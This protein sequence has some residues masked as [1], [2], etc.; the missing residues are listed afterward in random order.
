MRLAAFALLL[1][2]N[3]YAQPKP[4]AD[5]KPDSNGCNRGNAKACL[6][7]GIA[8][9]KGTGGVIKDETKAFEFYVKACNLNSGAGCGYAGTLQ[10]IGK[11]TQKNPTKGRALREKACN[12]LKYASSCND[13]GTAWAEGTDGATG[14][15][16]VKARNYYNDACKLGDGLGCFNLGN[17]HRLGEGGKID[18]ALAFQSYT[19]S[20][21]AN[22]AKGCSE[23]AIAHYEG[24][25]TPKDANKAV[26]F[27]EKACN[28]GSKVACKNLELVRPPPKEK[29]D[30]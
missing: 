4:T 24:K 9:I 12:T 25:G 11:G 19:K 29:D 30:K 13:L 27:L 17:A 7:T 14:K 3:A 20:C 15:D 2:A 28:M 1:G 6:D 21:N 8:Y 10:T 26:T 18:D 23:L 22:E 5:P 16:V